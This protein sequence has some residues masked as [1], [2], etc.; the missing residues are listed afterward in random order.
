MLDHIVLNVPNLEEAIDDFFKLTGSKAS[1][2]GY[3]KNEGTKNAL[4]S[5]GPKM[6]LEFLAV[7]ED[8]K[9]IKGNRWMGIDLCE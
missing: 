5:L 6:Y 3:H 9:K 4:I 7:D 2:G 8:N 1:F